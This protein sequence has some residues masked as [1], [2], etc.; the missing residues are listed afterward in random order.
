MFRVRCNGSLL[1]TPSRKAPPRWSNQSVYASPDVPGPGAGEC[2]GGVTST[3]SRRPGEFL[4]V[5]PAL[6]GGP[7]TDVVPHVLVDAQDRGSR[8]SRCRVP[9]RCGWRSHIPYCAGMGIILWPIAGLLLLCIVQF[10]AAV[11]APRFSRWYLGAWSAVLGIVVLYNVVT[12][13]ELGGSE[14]PGGQGAA[15]SGPGL[16]EMMWGSMAGVGV[17]MLW[18]A[19]LAGATIAWERRR[20]RSVD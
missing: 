3:I 9:G 19:D 11:I 1:G 6:F 18:F 8:P 13:L 12:F 17:I 10:V 15:W 7:G 2:G 20:R 14:T 16:N 5:P 4:R